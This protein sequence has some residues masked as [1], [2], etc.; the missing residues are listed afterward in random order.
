MN[1]RNTKHLIKKTPAGLSFSFRLQQQMG[2][3]NSFALANRY[4]EDG[5]GF[6][7]RWMRD[8]FFHTIRP[9][10]PTQPSL[11]CVTGHFTPGY[12]DRGVELTYC[13]V[14]LHKNGNTLRPS[15]CSIYIYIT[16]TPCSKTLLEKLIF[17]QVGKIFPA[18]MEP[19]RSL[20]CSRHHLVPILSHINPVHT[21]QAYLLNNYF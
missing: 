12:S 5:W 8:I 15:T 10:R 13:N 2:G 20:P 18:L 14:L 11:Q 16:K 1:K 17:L 7:L 4:G 6:E 19:E 21:L 9:E 3:E